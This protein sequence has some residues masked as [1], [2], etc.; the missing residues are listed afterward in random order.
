MLCS[1][2]PPATATHENQVSFEMAGLP[3]QWTPVANHSISL[4][5]RQSSVWQCWTV[6]AW[7]SDSIPPLHPT[8]YIIQWILNWRI[9]C[10]IEN[11]ITLCKLF[12]R[13]YSVY[14]LASIVVS[15][16]RQ[17]CCWWLLSRSSGRVCGSS[18]FTTWCQ[19]RVASHCCNW[20]HQ[21]AR[22]AVC[23]FLNRFLLSFDSFDVFNCNVRV[24]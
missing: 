12:L 20:H 8:H 2:C 5:A 7:I 11:H 1:K 6:L 15:V 3:Y 23:E 14:I 19:C 16:C 17:P 22:S 18:S 24:L 10:L 4:I 13:L 9:W 21:L